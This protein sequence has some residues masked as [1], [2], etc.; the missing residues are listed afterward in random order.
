MQYEVTKWGLP[1]DP[2][3]GLREARLNR[4]AASI[5]WSP[6]TDS[7]AVWAA[8]LLPWPVAPQLSVILLHFAM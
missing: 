5:T 3:K 1:V 6:Q 8:E 2:T 4:A 7:A